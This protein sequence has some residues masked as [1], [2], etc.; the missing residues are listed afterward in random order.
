[1]CVTDLFVSQSD[2]SA[3]SNPF[4][5]DISS[6]CVSDDGSHDVSP[7]TLML[8][9]AVQRDA[10]LARGQ[11]VDKCGR[12]LDDAARDDVT[13]HTRSPLPRAA[14]PREGERTSPCHAGV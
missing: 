3:G 8:V 12:P 9:L 11:K 5:W 2:T 1:M 14:T 7:L 4:S 10:A 6:A 13:T